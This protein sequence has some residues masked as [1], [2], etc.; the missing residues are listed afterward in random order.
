MQVAIDFLNTSIP[1]GHENDSAMRCITLL[2]ASAVMLPSGA[3]AQSTTRDPSDLIVMRRMI[4]PPKRAPGP[5][6]IFHWTQAPYGDY[7]SKCSLSTT[8]TGGEIS[9]VDQNGVRGSDASCEGGTRPT[10]MNPATQ[11]LTGCSSV[12]W[13]TGTRGPW[14]PSECSPSATYEIPSTCRAHVAVGDAGFVVADA[15]C[16]ASTKPTSPAPVVITTGCLSIDWMATPTG[17]Y[18]S[19]CS[20]A[21]TRPQTVAC[22][23]KSS[24][25]SSFTLPDARC[26]AATRPST[27]S[28]PTGVYSGC[29]AKWATTAWANVSGHAECSGSV[30]QTRTAICTATVSGKTTT[31]PDENCVA[32]GA[33]AGTKATV[34]TQNVSDYSA[35]TGTWTTGT[36][37]SYNACNPTTRTRS[38]VRNDV[39]TDAKGVVSADASACNPSS[40]PT[41]STTTVGCTGS[42]SATFATNK[43]LLSSDASKSSSF[44]SGYLGSVSSLTTSARQALAKQQCED[45]MPNGSYK[46]LMGC[47]IQGDF[48][49]S[50][51]ASSASY[52]IAADTQSGTVNGNSLAVC[53]AN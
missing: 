19:T 21:A 27:T 8:R 32:A 39:C 43:G 48:S 23:A 3:S 38:R 25:G 29:T 37:F 13:T 33:G 9:C 26:N 12:S 53:T 35:C 30:P 14:T 17:T 34:L 51:L 10:D 50:I 15:N 5:S 16:T 41:G 42:C 40:R 36:T 28:A 18:S 11:V 44:N 2:L 49:Y 22:T 7:L 45:V 46:Y 1:E 6:R 47:M 52:T 4:Q 20:S 24:D 31:I